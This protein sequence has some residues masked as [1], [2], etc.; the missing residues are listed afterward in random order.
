MEENPLTAQRSSSRKPSLPSGLAL[1]VGS[2][3]H[4]D[5][6]PAVQLMLEACPEAPC[7]PQLPLLGF[8]ETM[9]AQFS[10]GFPCLR[11]EPEKKKIAFERPESQWQ[12][13]TAFYEDLLRATHTNDHGSFAVSRA[14][15]SG[16]HA[17]IEKFP[18]SRQ[19]PPPF[20]K[21][22]VTGPISFG[23]SVMDEQGLP[24][25]Y[26]ETLSDVV[27]KGILMKSLWQIDRLRALAP[28]TI[29]FVDEPVL[30]SFGSAA[31]ISLTRERAVGCLREIFDAIKAS[32]TI[33]G[34]HCC[35]N[36]DWSL[37][38]EAGAD[39]IHFDA[40]L[41]RD[42]IGPYAE[43]VAGFLANG[44]FLAWG[45]VPSEGKN[46]HHSAEELYARLIEGIDALSSG[47]IPRELLEQNLLLSTS[48]GLGMLK[49]REAVAAMELLKGLSML[50]R[51]RRA[52]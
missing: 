1:A 7:W 25:L 32:G 26:D 12:G 20:V 14:Y 45:I 24:A 11:V 50:L 51:E 2:L 43:S 5:P 27:L 33:V 39:V 37:L 29:L 9:I 38:V 17:F 21:G 44:G 22:Q 13:L 46:L 18:L 35:G 23:L 28:A 30:A 41:Y 47:G 52:E 31:L 49:E 6:A 8:Q 48:C 34:S 40:Y 36:T 10:E 19:P 42:S 3:P 4:R 16:L 15:A